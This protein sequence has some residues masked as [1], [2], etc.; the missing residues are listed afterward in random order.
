MTA[1][2]FLGLT[3]GKPVGVLGATWIA[4]RTR[5]AAHPTDAS[6]TQ[7]LGASIMAGIGF[8][9]SLFIGNLGLGQ[10]RELEDQAKLG[11]LAASAASAVLGLI[12]LRFFSPATPPVQQEDVPVVLDVPDLPAAYGGRPCRVAGAL[13]GHTL[14]ELDV[15]RRFGVTVIGVWRGGKTAGARKRRAPRR[16]RCR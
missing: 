14:G 11:V 16:R 7:I 15:R 5:M 2:A 9:M 10:I 13:L 1:G 3:V 12:V 6:W 4:I 8:T